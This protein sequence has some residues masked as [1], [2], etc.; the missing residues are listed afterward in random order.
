MRNL[1]LALAC[2]F[3]ATPSHASFFEAC[4]VTAKVLSV[5]EL[6]VFGK[7]SVSVPS[8]VTPGDKEVYS[9][10][11]L[12]TLEVL[13]VEA[14]QGSYTDCK[15]MMDTH[16]KVILD[17]EDALKGF[18]AGDELKLSRK[19]QN[20]RTLNGVSYREVWNIQ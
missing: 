1:M 4:N 16:H 20:G 6:S 13:D 5:E 7:G 12:L 19:L 18:K 2:L 8:S 9:F 17:S 14:E 15:R 10:V 11:H 3:S